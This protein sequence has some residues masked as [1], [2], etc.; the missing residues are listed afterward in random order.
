MTLEDIKKLLPHFQKWK[1]NIALIYGMQ[2]AEKY[3]N[4]NRFKDHLD[5]MK[6]VFDENQSINQKT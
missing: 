1:E 5:V 4:W 6:E 3:C 2:Y